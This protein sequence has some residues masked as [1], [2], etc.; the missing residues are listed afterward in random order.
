MIIIIPI[1]DFSTELFP[2]IKSNRENLINELEAFYSVGSIKPIVKIENDIITIE[3]DI[4]NIE[5][6]QSKFNSLIELCNKGEFIKALPLAN[7]LV[8]QYPS[9]SEYHR[10]LGQINSELGNQDEAI[11]SLIDS[12]KWNPK[13]SWALIMMGNIFSRFKKDVD[14]AMIYYNEVI[15]NNPNDYLTLNNIGATLLQLGNYGEAKNYLIKASEQ[16][17]KYPN[18]YFG[19]AVV[20]FN[21]NN[22]SDSFDYLLKAFQLNPLKDELY[23]NSIGL[24]NQ[25]VI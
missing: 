7:E 10:I 5:I 11:D 12:L 21:E 19:L 17:D 15:K 13:N 14:T 2:N 3:I 16:N 4:K 23:N 8:N 6:E 1:S 20:Y 9:N 24:L 25:I 18:T 22:Y